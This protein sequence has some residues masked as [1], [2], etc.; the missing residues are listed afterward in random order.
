MMVK[1]NIDRKNVIWNII[2]A[3]AN[4]FN[5]LFFTIIV[6]RINGTFDA[7]IFS[8]SFATACMLYMVGV[9]AGRTFQ[10]TDISKENSDTDYIYNRSITCIIM[11]IVSVLFVIIKGYDTYKSIIFVLLCLFKCSEAFVEVLYGVLQKNGKLYKVGISMFVKAV[12]SLVLFLIIDAITKN[13]M[14][15]CISI[16][17]IN[18]LIML[19]YDYKNIKQ[20]NLIKTKYSNK[21]NIRL[22]KIG[23]CTFILTFLGIY[24]INAPRYAIDDI[25]T[26]DIQTIFGI[27]IMPATFMGLLGQYII[28]PCLT[29][30]S[31]NI[32]N[33]NYN[34]LKN[35]IKMLILI[36][37][38]FG[39]IVTIVAWLL[40]VPV[41]ELVYG[42]SLSNYFES[43]MI[44][45]IGSILYSLS[46]I[47]S[48]I[49]IA[50]RKT[51]Y[52]VIVYI[53]ISVIAT[54]LAYNLVNVIQIKGAAIAYFIAMLM[55]SLA[56]AIYTIINMKEYKRNWRILNE[57]N[58]NNSNI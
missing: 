39:I 20:I 3:T 27:I 56:F 50:M 15:A 54:V 10:V 18:I 34:N 30:I 53:I 41:L 37:L 38:A 42:I 49:L 58:N 46:T 11:V 48:A 7:G 43:M 32:K 35:I 2:G 12:I 24:L 57:N 25:L 9:Y 8:Y 52:Q 36:I 44:I 31:E 4:A 51:L 16:L 45:I 21:V 1:E 17:I 47:L 23:F 40:E 55:V 5:S 22:F 19:I 33:E 14:L 26:N 28:Q 6:T 13:L 29:K